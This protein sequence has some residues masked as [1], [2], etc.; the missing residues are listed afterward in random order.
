MPFNVDDASGGDLSG[1]YTA[2]LFSPQRIGDQSTNEHFPNPEYSRGGAEVYNCL[3]LASASTSRADRIRLLG[4]P[5]E[6]GHTNKRS[7]Q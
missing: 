2:H 3:L 1:D 6:H 4:P 5:R 7:Q